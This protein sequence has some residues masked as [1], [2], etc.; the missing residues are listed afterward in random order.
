M[1]ILAWFVLSFTGI[2]LLVALINAMSNLYLPPAG[3]M[4]TE[5][6]LSVLIP[7]R[8][9]E[10][11]L[12][13]LLEM[14]INH[15]YHN[16]EII[17]YNDQ[18]ED[19]T[20]DIIKEYT[21]KDNR[22]SYING[23]SL[24]KGWVGKTYACHKLSFHA[25]GDYFLFIDADV[26]IKN[27]LFHNAIDYL[28]QK[29]LTL[30][31]IF[32]QQIM[33]SKGEWFTVPLMNWILLS[34]LPLICVKQTSFQLFSGANGQFMLF[35]GAD[36]RQNRWHE[37]VKSQHVEDIL[38]MR[39]IKKKRYSV[40]TLL[41][42]HDIYCRMY[43]SYKEGVNGFAKNVKQFF[44]GNYF[45]LIIVL[46]LVLAGIIPV[47]IQLDPIFVCLYLT[48]II[49]IKIL[50]SVK[51]KQSV[52]KNIIYHPVQMITFA[53]IVFS[54]IIKRKRSGYEWKGRKINTKT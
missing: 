21:K 36:Y 48:G 8:N 53:H 26:S 14:L 28:K 46:L 20:E 9:E 4:D 41:G 43:H 45:T 2:R 15:P 13:Q 49:C 19:H 16:I 35:N 54:S 30:L 34:F 50:T 12:S 39:K 1:E 52:L 6:L 47:I 27:H 23:E 32:P 3:K 42:Y 33:K 38:I 44:G 17:I 5:P 29:K 11:N 18:S 37:K 7:A 24:P 10:K 40:D 51:S 25:K 22:I 31:S